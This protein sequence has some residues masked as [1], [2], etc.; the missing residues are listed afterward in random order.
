V[1]GLFRDLFQYTCITVTLKTQDIISNSNSLLK[2]QFTAMISYLTVI[3]NSQSTLA[4]F[5]NLYSSNRVWVF[6]CE[7]EVHDCITNKGVNV[8]HGWLGQIT[9]EVEC[10]NERTSSWGSVIP[11]RRKR[12]ISTVTNSV[13][14]NPSGIAQLFCDNGVLSGDVVELQC[15][16]VDV[17]GQGAERCKEILLADLVPDVERAGVPCRSALRFVGR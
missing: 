8:N 3:L 9:W 5:I 15:A 10:A 4:I 1:Y 12:E 6:D 11:S 13:N 14:V 16:S 2:S 7:S 17:T